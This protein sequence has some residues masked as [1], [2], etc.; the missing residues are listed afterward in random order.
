M[1]TIWLVMMVADQENI[2]QITY[3]L[4]FMYDKGKQ[5]L[6][7]DKSECHSLLMFAKSSQENFSLKT[8]KDVK[9]GKD[10]IIG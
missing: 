5:K 2:L 3:L 7:M 1:W 9:M 8:A 10:K 4:W 6:T